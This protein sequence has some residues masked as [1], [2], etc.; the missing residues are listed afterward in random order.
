[1]KLLVTG[2]KGQLE[3]QLKYIIEKNSSDTGEFDGRFKDCQCK[4]VDYDK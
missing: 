1:M 3:C 2:G 4:L